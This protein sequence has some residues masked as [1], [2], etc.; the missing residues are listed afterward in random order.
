VWSPDGTEI[1]LTYHTEAGFLDFHDDDDVRVISASSGLG[2]T[3]P[4]GSGNNETSPS[5]SPDGTKIAYG[6]FDTDFLAA[7]SDYNQAIEIVNPDGSGG[8]RL[9]GAWFNYADGPDWSPD[10]SKLVYVGSF[11]QLY[12]ENVDGSSEHVVAAAGWGPAWSPDGTK[13][14]YSAWSSAASAVEIYVMNADG[15]GAKPLVEGSSPSWQPTKVH[16]IDCL[17]AKPLGG[18]GALVAG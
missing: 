18:T 15:T 8:S 9:G 7:F 4:G 11:R 12:T 2:T 10:G 6:F 16:L 14:A 3:T 1:A 13:I 5:W 17:I